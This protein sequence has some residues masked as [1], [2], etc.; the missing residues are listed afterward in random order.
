[1]IRSCK[2]HSL[3]CQKDE[4][5]PL[6]RPMAKFLTCPQGHQWEQDLLEPKSIKAA[7]TCPV[8]G[9]STRASEGNDPP[10]FALD[11]ETLLSGPPRQEDPDQ[12]ADP[13]A[14]ISRLEKAQSVESNPSLA[15]SR[16]P[17]LQPSQDEAYRTEPPSGTDGTQTREVK[18]LFPKKLRGMLDNDAPALTGYEIL[19]E[20]GRGGM[21]IVYQAFDKTRGQVV[22]LKTLQ[23]L[24]PGSLYRFKQDFRTLANVVHP[25]LVSLYELL[26]DGRQWAFTMEL[27]EGVDF[28]RWVRGEE[29]RS[30]ASRPA[31][32]SA[33]TAPQLERLRHV[34]GQLATAVGVLHDAGKLHRDLKSSNAMVT[35]EG[36]LVLLDFGLAAEL[37]RSGS[38]QS[39]ENVVGTAAYMAPEQAAGQAVTRASDWYSVGVMIYES[40]TGTLPFQSK[41]LQVLLD[42]QKLDPVHPGKLVPEV[43]EDLGKL[44]MELLERD[45]TKRPDGAEVLRR[46]QPGSV[47]WNRPAAAPPSRRQAG[48]LLGRADHLA[49]LSEAFLLTRQGK[50]ALVCVHGLS[51]AGKSALAQFFVDDLVEGEKAIVLSGRCYEQESVPYKALDSL[52]DALS[53]YL[54]QLPRLEAEALLPRDVHSL[55]RVFPVLRRVSAVAET[56]RRGGEIPDL[57]ELRRRASGGLRELLGRMSDR[58]PL[59]LY[60]DDLQWGDVDS[61]NLLLDVLRPPEPPTLFVLATY[62]S[63]DVDGSPFLQLFLKEVEKFDPVQVRDQLECRQLAVEALSAAEAR[64]LAHVLL[65]RVD[66][67]LKAH[68][69]TIARESGGNPFF[70]YELV[71]HFQTHGGRGEEFV[72]GGA[73]TLDNVLR[74]RL[75]RLPENG[76]RLLEIMAVAGRPLPQADACK[77]AGLLSKER[78]LLA[79][80]KANRLIRSKGMGAEDEIETYHDRVR[81]TVAGHLDRATLKSHHLQLALTLEEARHPDPEFLALHW[82]GAEELAKAST[83]Y[84]R[85]ADRAANA[86]A[87]DRAAHLYERALQHC[88]Q[89]E[90]RGLLKK[91]A[92]AIANAGRGGE[93]AQVFLAAAE[94]G[95]PNE[96][97]ELRRRAAEQLLWSG[98]ID[99]GLEVLRTVLTSIGLKLPKTPL[100]ALLSYLWQRTLLWLRGLNFRERSEDQVSP[101]EL[102]H[103]DTCWSVAL[104][105]GHVDMIRGATFQ[106]RHLRLALRAGEPYRIARALAMEVVNSSTAG[107]V[108]HERTEQLFQ[109]ALALAERVPQPHAL[110]MA[111]LCG[112]MAAFLEGF[113]KRTWELCERSAAILRERCTGVSWELHSAKF[114]GIRALEFLGEWRELARRLPIYIKDAQDRGDLFAAT[115][116]RTRITYMTLL[117]ADKPAEASEEL[118]RAM[119]QWAANTG[120]HLQHYFELT[121]KVCISL[122]AGTPQTA[123]ELMDRHWS[124]LSRSLLLRVQSSR[125]TLLQFR[126]CTSLALLAAGAPSASDRDKLL[127]SCAQDAE[128]MRKC[129]MGWSNPLA[130]LAFAGSAAIRGKKGEAVQ[131]LASAE[132]GFQAADMAIFD[133]VARRRRGQLLG[134]DEGRA[135]VAEADARMSS[136]M[137]VNPARVS[138]MYA[139]G[140][141]D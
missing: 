97:L 15:G 28:F 141:P 16:T 92:E 2:A 89:E 39:S 65:G 58:K 71:Q 62:R 118:A 35:K 73:L 3:F 42:K 20:L 78:G 140:F 68:T 106:L 50:A 79:E 94:G 26:S 137:I 66:P 124:A 98:R 9:A 1:M 100:R 83:Y 134:G 75:S 112:G 101:Q 70:V 4:V 102:L 59:V 127:R 117:M 46:L 82:E 30:L 109:R 52:V 47:Q 10:A 74:E 69:E 87:F 56:P 14:T 80:L 40:L 7:V 43:P 81:E 12:T 53:T 99:Q 88:P 104:G 37:A 57:Q 125:I 96:Q 108:T 23:V 24:N 121:A 31:P 49:A 63:E 60:I 130:L 67:A 19:G 54:G 13:T 113:W 129:N 29:E 41:G 32:P 72:E 8:C 6:G 123:Q 122:Y 111:T 22:A 27:V 131:L 132:Q 17:N 55:A 105:L 103:I 44:C 18:D 85:A 138:A 51:G 116:F 119:A 126:A 11:S 36:R 135:L 86:L 77:A 114:Y 25:N 136:Q 61:A 38:Y 5:N 45:P 91:R 33:L 95:A 133:A 48:I 115:N 120:V 139:P 90:K 84:V 21:G 76:R 64:D 110:G 93:A 34:L 128:Q 107:G